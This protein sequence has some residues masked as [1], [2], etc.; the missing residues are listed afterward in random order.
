MTHDNGDFLSRLHDGC[1]LADGLNEGPAS[2]CW[3]YGK[4]ARLQLLQSL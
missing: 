4:Y 3:N 1:L 2:A